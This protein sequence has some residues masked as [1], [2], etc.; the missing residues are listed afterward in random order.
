MRYELDFAD[1]ANED[2]ERYR[3]YDRIAILTLIDKHLRHEPARE[4]KSR[5]KALQG[6]SRPQYRLRVGD[7]RVFYDVREGA[8]EVI[9]VVDK[10]DA[11]EWLEREGVKA[12]RR[13][14]P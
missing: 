13:N 2:L 10:A 5:I 7:I 9:A 1:E 4:S 12:Q 8:V 3:A 6:L 14:E 11:A